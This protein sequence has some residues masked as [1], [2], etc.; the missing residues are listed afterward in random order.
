[1]PDIIIIGGGLAGSEAAWQAAERGVSVRIYEMRPQVQTPAHFTG[2]LGELVC[3]NSLRA[4][5]IHNAAGLL[6][7]ELKRVGS[8]IM[9]CAV[10]TE[11]PAGGALAVDREAFSQCITQKIEQHPFIEVVRQEIDKIPPERP[12]IIAS[13]PL[14]SD[15]LARSIFD[16][17]GEEYLYFY[18]AA[19]PIV[20]ADS[21]NYDRVF[22]ASR[23]DQEATDYINCPMTRE[24]Y[25]DFWEAL[26]SAEKYIPHLEEEKK[27][28]EGCMPVEVMAERGPD[29]LLFGPMKPVGLVDPRTGE[30]PYAVVQ[31]RQ[32]NLSATLY[33]MVGFQTQLKWPEQKRVFRMIPGLENAEFARF[34]MMHRNTFLNAPR[35]L[36][37]T[38]EFHD[39]PGVFVAGQ[40]SGVE[41]YVESTASGLVAGLNAVARVQGKDPIEF[42][43]ET[44]IGSLSQYITSADQKHFQPMNITFG[45]INPPQERI[46]KKQRRDYLANR[47]LDSLEKFRKVCQGLLA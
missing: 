2:K 39:L 6:K 17:V 36:K 46:P 1:M 35:L 47:A 26:V 10:N 44:A 24:E 29:T 7:E 43:P 5:S 3:S 11:V 42:P 40:L 30:Q 14:T 31:L 23:Y 25:Y 34:G 12:L 37:T 9:E 8:L 41:G 21:L 19:A 38:Y 4:S 33:N 16:V 18:D 45:M 32:D 28:F 22:H 15:S 20:N 27:F 13:G